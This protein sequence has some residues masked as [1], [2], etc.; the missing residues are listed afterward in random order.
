MNQL[1]GRFV[2]FGV[3]V[4][5]LP[6][7]PDFHIN[8]EIRNYPLRLL[9]PSLNRE[10]GVWFEDF[11]GLEKA[12]KNPDTHSLTLLADIYTQLRKL[13]LS[14]EHLKLFYP[15]RRITLHRIPHFHREVLE[16]SE[17]PNRK[18]LLA[19]K[20]KEAPKEVLK[21]LSGQNRKLLLAGKG[22]GLN[23][24]IKGKPKRKFKGL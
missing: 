3:G 1:F 23:I 22:K 18:I 7:R 2:P 8:G 15:K 20:R 11:N 6:N 9:T 17:T 21:E 10:K 13:T 14:P 5:Q 4:L 16:N 12:T 19:E 24:D